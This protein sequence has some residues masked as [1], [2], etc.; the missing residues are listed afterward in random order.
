LQKSAKLFGLLLIAAGVAV[1]AAWY[2]IPAP[3]FEVVT[4]EPVKLQDPQFDPVTGESRFNFYYN[5]VQNR[6][7]LFPN[8]VLIHPSLGVKLAAYT[9]AAA[10]ENEKFQKFVG[11]GTRNQSS[12]LFDIHTGTPLRRYHRTAD[13]RIELFPI[14][15][16]VHP[17]LGTKLEF[18]ERGLAE[19]YQNQRPLNAPAE[20]VDIPQPV[21]SHFNIRT[22][23]PLKN[24]FEKP[25]GTIELFD[26]SVKIHPILGLP[27]KP[28]T[29]ETAAKYEEQKAPRDGRG[30]ASASAPELETVNNT[31]IVTRGSRASAFVPQT[32]VEES[33]PSLGAGRYN[34]KSQ[35]ECIEYFCV[36]IESVEISRVENRVSSSGGP[37]SL[38]GGSF[39]RVNL[40]F[41]G[42][43]DGDLQPPDEEQIFLVDDV[44]TR[45]PLQE[46]TGKFTVAMI[47]PEV[48]YVVPVS[49]QGPKKS[50]LTRIPASRNPKRFLAEGE[51][52]SYSLLFGPLSPDATA[53]TLTFGVVT[54][55]TVKLRV[56]LR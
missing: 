33:R 52:Y 35:Q 36:R 39:T 46:H 19:E 38:S 29:P 22:G 50:G 42:Q 16:A 37:R 30:A 10:A 31:P 34:V 3:R 53:I 12:D 9:K 45:Y 11:S 32:I 1:F 21:A 44:G 2:Q 5:K 48:M 7:E 18:F 41:R 49:F 56:S 24:Y 13:G 17:V 8:D 55:R 4:P 40:W 26:I 23:E 54:S 27:L 15:V 28:I 51:V 47:R 25:D 6:I 20:N 43:R 14:D